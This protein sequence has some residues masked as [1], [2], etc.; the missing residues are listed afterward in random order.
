MIRWMASLGTFILLLTGVFA[1]SA[2]AE[3]ASDREIAVADGQT[4]EVTSFGGSGEFVEAATGTSDQ[5]YVPIQPCRVADTR[6]A[7]GSMAA[8]EVRDFYITGTVGFESQG[9]TVGGCGVPSN[10]SAV[11]INITAPNASGNGWLRVW[12]TDQSAPNATILSYTSVFSASNAGAVSVCNTCSKQLRMKTFTYSTHVLLDVFGY[13]VDN[14]V[15]GYSITESIANASATWYA[16]DSAV[17]P[18]GTTLIGGGTGT[19]TIA[20]FVGNTA[21]IA[22]DEWYSWIETDDGV[23]NSW[24]QYTYAICAKTS[25]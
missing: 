15:P 20:T 1:V 22:S 6:A 14:V 3:Q 24:E 5:V 9:G 12:P 21:P 17:C 10:A 25:R 18:P 19:E 13:Y 8:D 4:K 11:E 23:A 7:G 16:Q 2:G